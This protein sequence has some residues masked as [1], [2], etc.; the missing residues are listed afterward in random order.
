MLLIQCH[1]VTFLL[2]SKEISTFFVC[3]LVLYVEF[4]RVCANKRKDLTAS[5]KFNIKT[6]VIVYRKKEEKV[7]C[8]WQYLPSKIQSWVLNIV[9]YMFHQPYWTLF[10]PQFCIGR[11]GFENSHL[12]L[13]ETGLK[14]R[15]KY[16]IINLFI[17]KMWRT[18]RKIYSYAPIKKSVFILSIIW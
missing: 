14:Q 1:T 18:C 11:R 9:F 4:I 16:R 2:W 8:N 15:Y 7:F 13:N 5:F 12:N 17:R 3:L 10:F 6:E